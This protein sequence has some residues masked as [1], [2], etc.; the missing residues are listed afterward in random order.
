QP[1]FGRVPAVLRP[2]AFSG[3]SPFIYEGPIVRSVGDAALAMQ[4][5]A[6]Y[7][8]ADPFS[9]LDAPDFVSAPEG[10]IQGWKIAY[11]PDLGVYPV[12]PEVRTV[13]EQA[14]KAFEEAGAE[15]TEVT[16]DLD[17]DQRDLA[18]LWCRLIMPLNLAAFASLKEG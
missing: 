6:G 17:L 11:S 16:L 2:N 13:V 18:D 8:P 15:V 10:S 5:L 3:N 12:A 4:A 14:V 1:S 9:L 7:H